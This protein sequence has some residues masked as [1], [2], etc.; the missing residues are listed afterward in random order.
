V[1]IENK[2]DVQAV[3]AFPSGSLQGIAELENREAEE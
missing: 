2:S 3:A 1:T